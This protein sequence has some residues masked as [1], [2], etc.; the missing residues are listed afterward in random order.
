AIASVLNVN[1]SISRRTRSVVMRYAAKNTLPPMA[2]RLPYI[3]IGA[4]PACAGPSVIA[5][6]P[7][8]DSDRPS[9]NDARG[10]LRRTSHDRIPTNTGVLL[11]RID[12]T[13]APVCM[14]E[15]FHSAMSSAKNTP[16]A[17]ATAAARAVAGT[18]APRAALHGTSNAPATR[19]R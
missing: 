18:R 1:V 12:A 8:S 15:V 6:Q 9:Q 16:P 10:R 2:I 7:A 19:T 14:T 3:V 17:N 5:R 4:E 13:A 11:P